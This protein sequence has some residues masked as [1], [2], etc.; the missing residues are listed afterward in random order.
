V[1]PLDTR[2]CLHPA[3]L[4]LGLAALLLAAAPLRAQVNTATAGSSYRCIDDKG[5]ARVSDR[6]IRECN[7]R[8]QTILN[9]DG[10]VRGK[11]PPTLTQEERAERD[12]AERR[13]LEARA[14]Q[15]DEIRKD[16]NLKARFP[17]EAAHSK[18]REAALDPVR[19]AMKSSE[20]RLQ[21]LRDERKPLVDEAEFYKGKTMPAKLKQQLEGNDA[22]TAAQRE[23]ILNQEAEVGRINKLFDIELD[24]LRRLWN[25][26]QP[27]TLGSA[28]VAPLV[29][30]EVARR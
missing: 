10:S 3:A 25:G 20:Q 28:A 13:Q 15:N 19:R 7:D 30:A 22:A 17:N 9:K 8:E 29:K 24:R 27:G 1:R 16:R 23:A 5:H 26:A 2:R 11:M 6:P 18:A 14:A 4:G 12:A 21:E